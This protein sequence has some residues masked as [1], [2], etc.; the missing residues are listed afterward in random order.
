LNKLKTAAAN[1][2]TVV[3]AT[4]LSLVMAEIASRYLYH[5]EIAHFVDSNG[6]PTDIRLNDP[7]LEF[8]LKPDF[9]G[10][11]IG[12]E[13][14][15]SVSTNSSGFRDNK[16]FLKKRAA[17]IGSS[18]SATPLFLDGVLKKIKLS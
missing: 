11:Q 18:A 10:G 8:K 13:F 6:K 3:V 17:H 15:V 1:V 5:V 4:L 7:E 14:Q 2:L 12:S 9:R 16:Q